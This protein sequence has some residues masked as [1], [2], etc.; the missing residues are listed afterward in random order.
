MQT[1]RRYEYAAGDGYILAAADVHRVSVLEDGGC[2]TITF[3]HIGEEPTTA[4]VYEENDKVPGAVAEPDLDEDSTMQMIA[5]LRQEL[6]NATQ[7]ED[8]E[9]R[10]PSEKTPSLSTDESDSQDMDWKPTMPMFSRS[11]SDIRYLTD[12]T[13]SDSDSSDALPKIPLALVR[14][15]SA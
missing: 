8:A 6:A 7:F 4:L 14:C 15:R 2:W 12:N 13:T 11:K 5:E 9:T 10:E 1:E 3:R